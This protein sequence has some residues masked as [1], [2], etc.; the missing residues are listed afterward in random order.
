MKST[1]L[2]TSGE[3]AELAGVD[4]VTV[5]HWA[6]DG[7]LPIVAKANRIRLFARSDVEALIAKREAEAAS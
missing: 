3:V 7:K 4:R 6:K 1:D 2:L 5:H